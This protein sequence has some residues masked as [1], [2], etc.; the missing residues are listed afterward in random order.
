LLVR[1]ESVADLRARVAEL[2]GAGSG[3]GFAGGAGSGDAEATALRFRPNL[4]VA[5]GA[6]GP[7]DE[8]AWARVRVGGVRLRSAAPC[9]RCRMINIDPSSGRD[10]PEWLLALGRYRRQKYRTL[11]GQLM[12]RVG[13]D[14]ATGA[15]GATLREGD[16]LAV[17]ERR[18]PPRF[19]EE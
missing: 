10:A 16:A 18:S 1:E 6:G 13:S 4:V 9:P 12:A 17:E 7:Y 14:G 11:F 2:R 5:G 19:A 8:D 15:D 3:R